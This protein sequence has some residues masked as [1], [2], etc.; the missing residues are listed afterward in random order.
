[1]TARLIQ[2]LERFA[3]S[4]HGDVKHLKGRTDELRLRVG[5]WRIRFTLADD[6]QTVNVLRILPRGRA[7]RD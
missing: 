7:Y 5:A 6:G 2:A 4:G 3:A 1:M